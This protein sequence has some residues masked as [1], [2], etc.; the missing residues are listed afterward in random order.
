M[1]AGGGRSIA[2]QAEKRIGGMESVEQKQTEMLYLKFQEGRGHLVHDASGHLP[3]AEI[4]YR[5][6]N[7][8]YIP[9]RDPSWRACGIQ[10]SALLFDGNSTCICYPPEI[11]LRGPSL[12]L[13]AWIAPRSFPCGDPEASE[14]DLKGITAVLG[15]VDPDAP[16]GIL[17]GYEAFGRPCLQIGTGDRR[18]TLR[19]ETARL[20]SGRW[21]HLAGIW[22]EAQAAMALYVNGNPAGTLVLPR[23]ARFIP[24]EGHP[25]MIGKNEGGKVISAGM[26][27][28]FCGLMGE[29]RV[30]AAALSPEEIAARAS[31]PR[32]EIPWEDIGPEDILRA[33]P[34]R[35]RFHGQPRQHWMNEPHAPLY[36][37]GHY[38]L[39]FQSN[40]IGSYWGNIAWGHLV[41]EDTVRWRQVQDAIVPAE[42]SVTPDGVWTGGATL[43][44]NG[45]PVLFFTAAD[46]TYAAHGL[47]S[48]QNIGAA[49]PKDPNDPELREWHV[50]DRLAATQQA[51]RGRPG[52]FRDPHVWREADGWYMAVC[53]GSPRTGGGAVLLFRTERLEVLP[54]GK[55]DMDWRYLGIAFDMDD[56]PPVY[57]TSWELPVL[58]PVENRAGSIRKHFLFLMPAPPDRADNKVYYY[59]GAFDRQAGKFIP[60]PGFGKE[61]RLL[62]Y[63]D[64]I[65]TGPS[66]LKDP[67]TGRL[68][69]FSIMQDKRR[70]AEEAE[71]GWAHCAGLTRNLYLNDA[72]TDLCVEA[73]PRLESLFSRKLADLSEVSV[74]EANQA[75][76]EIREDLYCLRAEV[77]AGENVSLY[78]R[79]SD[80]G[81][82][83][84]FRYDPSAKTLSGGTDYPGAFGKKEF[85]RGTLSA[86]DTALTMDL[87]VDHSLTEGFFN[88]EKA[89][90][91]R[92]YPPEDSRGIRFAG[93]G[94]TRIRRL[95]LWQMRPSWD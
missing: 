11:C 41:S 56:Q 95:Q 71:A 82:G 52:E 78:L 38:H 72:G 44:A 60:D 57:G 18:H 63:G 19:A 4:R 6:R 75:L 39:F 1:T 2:R 28:M 23:G 27:D 70:P 87:Y 77:D 79:T 74:E 65:F 9:S 37:R 3:A 88:G 80:A 84:I 91:I 61:P 40:N 34:H 8:K 45:I 26:M 33:D 73:D 47:I 36:F 76:A 94:T 35:T 85:M 54:E 29:I 43:D 7:A 69:L 22:D 64:N 12:T 42:N 83:M 10:G 49:W 14:G 62:D 13:S 31:L 50:L 66:V 17:L 92:S 24:A 16:R 51:G 48:N 32:P 20:V 68:C 59:V 30:E 93:G 90:S 5:F 86:T 21:N 53:G 58:M 89:L 67:V 46:L 15:Q 81:S 55:I 25:L